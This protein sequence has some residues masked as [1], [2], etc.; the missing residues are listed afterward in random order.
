MFGI[1][2]AWIFTVIWAL[3]GLMLVIV[4]GV[5]I[6]HVITRW[7]AVS[8]ARAIRDRAEPRAKARR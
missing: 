6:N 7:Q 2:L 1:N 8:Q 4:L 3:W 5:V